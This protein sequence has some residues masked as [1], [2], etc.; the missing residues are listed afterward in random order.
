MAMDIAEVA[1]IVGHV[2]RYRARVNHAAE[3]I[4]ATRPR[5]AMIVARG[6]S[7]HVG[8]YLQYL[9]ASYCGV[10]TG[11]AVPSATTVYG[12]RLG[13][14]HG[15]LIAVSQSG[16]SPDVRQLVE[17]A[18][19]G[20]A[21]TVAITNH[22]GAPVGL[23]AEYVLDCLAGQERA[24]PA[25]K[26]Y[27]ACLAVSACLV[28]D[29]APGSELATGMDR[30]VPAVEAAAADAGAW[31]DGRGGR[32]LDDLAGAD[33]A[34]V[35]SR[36]Y[37]LS[38]AYETALKLKEACRVFA[39]GYSSADVLHGPMVVAVPGIP[40]LAFRPDGPI[41]TSI[42]DA[43]AAAAARGIHPW[44]VGGD[45]VEGQTRALSLARDLP[46]SLTPLP[47]AIMGQLL[48]ERLAAR[49]GISP[50]APHGLSK[51]TRTL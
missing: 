43:I 21:L 12:A 48:A 32:L 7:D 27:V 25:T 9:L 44:L 10:P 37:N 20:G 50:D 2:V 39:S 19:Q 42:D 11:L 41:G 17:E 4:R 24:I 35:I 14:R 49:L 34:L 23:A 16:Q 47:Y 33:R 22:P 5:W 15:L 28:A 45:E 38:T 18:R 30:I 36:G 8:S 51:V 3:A 46:E 29:L 1:E 26:T 13:W 40:V 6:S 31:L